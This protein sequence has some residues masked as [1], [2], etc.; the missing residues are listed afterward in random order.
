M[1]CQVSLLTDYIGGED[2]IIYLI[3]ILAHRTC[4]V[5]NFQ[6]AIKCLIFIQVIKVLYDNGWPGGINMTALN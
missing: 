3:V 2:N 6:G 1:A 4:L 5:F